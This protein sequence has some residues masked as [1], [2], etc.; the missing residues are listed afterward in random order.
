[1]D[2]PE[3]VQSCRGFRVATSSAASGFAQPRQ[4]RALAG[5]DVGPR[6]GAASGALRRF[7]ARRLRAPSAAATIFRAGRAVHALRIV[8]EPSGWR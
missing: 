6:R 3:R 2:V 8:A 4:S 7:A 1:M 5:R